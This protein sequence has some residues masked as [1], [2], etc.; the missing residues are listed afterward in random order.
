MEKKIPHNKEKTHSTV[1]KP[2]S[3]GIPWL[4]DHGSEDTMKGALLAQRE[5]RGERERERERERVYICLCV[6]MERK[7]DSFVQ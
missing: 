1:K 6:S 7:M 5:R 4:C 3:E 2:S